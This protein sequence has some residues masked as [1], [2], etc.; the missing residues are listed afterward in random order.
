MTTKMATSLES[1]A[2][3]LESDIPGSKV[4]LTC[5][6]SGGAMV[7]VRRSDN[8]TFVLA[9]SPAHGYAVDEVHADDGFLSGYRFSFPDFN[10]AAEKLNELAANRHADTRPAP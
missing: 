7:D 2:I 3:G 1:L 4:E 6:P 10:S 8:R 9:Y 5:F